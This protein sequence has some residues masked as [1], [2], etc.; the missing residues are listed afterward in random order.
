MPAVMNAA[1]EVAVAAFLAG[2]CRFTDIDAVVERAMNDHA[3]EE[4][5]S[6]EHVESYDVWA[7]ARAAAALP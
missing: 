1:N 2:E 7:R 4:I 5:E 6:L 3:A